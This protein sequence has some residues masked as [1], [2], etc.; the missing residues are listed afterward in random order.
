MTE[1]AQAANKPHPCPPPPP[2]SVD[3]ETELQKL[4]EREAKDKVIV[5]GLQSDLKDIGVA[6]TDLGKSRDEI[7]KA[8]DSYRIANPRTRV[9]QAHCDAHKKLHC[10]AKKVQE[11][12]G[13]DK[14]HELYELVE[15]FGQDVRDKACDLEGA[16]FS[17]QVAQ[18][19]KRKADEKLTAEKAKLRDML[20]TESNSK[21]P[22]TELEQLR[23][24]MHDA[25]AKNDAVE[26]YLH[27]KEI[28]RRHDWLVQAYPEPDYFCVDLI[29]QWGVVYKAQKDVWAKNEECR[30]HEADVERLTI[31]LDGKPSGWRTDPLGEVRR[32]WKEKQAKE[33]RTRAGEEP[34][35]ATPSGD[36]AG[37]PAQQETPAKSGDQP[38]PGDTERRDRDQRRKELRQE[39]VTTEERKRELEGQL[40]ATTDE[41]RQAELRE[42]ISE[43]DRR[44]TKIDEELAG[45]GEEGGAT[46]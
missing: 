30:K 3:P 29:E 35:A 45:L 7:K 44:M 26:A 41:D 2:P 17:L 34:G 4:R 1:T 16:R 32:R 6:I 46:P 18:S 36:A 20:A 25:M 15:K 27:C 37:G 24:G 10:L 23:K 12:L 31:L 8:C 28:L 11:L 22:L 13:N 38:P 40:H 42:K 19:H 43:T 21:V 33:T 14:A 9:E 39:R 5:T